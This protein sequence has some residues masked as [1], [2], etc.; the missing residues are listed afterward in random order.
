[1]PN[2][3]KGELHM[4]NKRNLV[5]DVI[6]FVAFLAI[7][8]PSLTG[9]TIHEWLALAFATAI[10]THLLFHWKWLD[11]VTQ[12]FFRKLFHLLK[13]RLPGPSP[14]VHEVFTI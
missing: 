3:F 14:R 10:V 11:Q 6:I 1:M 12:K 8:N 9:M 13:K 2:K 7:A 5:L 4:S